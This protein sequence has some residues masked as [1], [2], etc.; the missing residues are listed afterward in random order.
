MSGDQLIADNP[1][2]EKPIW[3]SESGSLIYPSAYGGGQQQGYAAPST[4][5]EPA[6]GGGFQI[7]GL[8]G[9]R[10]TSTYRTPAHN[11][12][13]G[14]VRNSYHT[15]RDAQGNPL[16]RDSVP[17]AGMSMASYAARLRSENPDKDVINEGDHVHIEPRGRGPQA[18]APTQRV[19]VVN[20]RAPRERAG[21]PERAP[22]GYRFNGD[23]LEAIP[24][25]PADKRGGGGDAPTRREVVGLR[26]EFNALPEV[27]TFNVA[28]QQFNTLRDLSYKKN[29]TPQD[30]IAIVFAFMKTLDPSSVVKETEFA[31]AAN[32]ASVPESVRNMYN[33]ALQGTRL[34]A[35][36][37]KQMA[38]T[39]FVSYKAFREAH[40]QAAEQYR[41]YARGTGI[42]PDDVART[43]TPDKPARTTR[44]VQAMKR[45]QTQRIG[46]F[47]VTAE[48]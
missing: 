26:K 5:P 48:N 4:R 29:P 42:R 28:R 24:G 3:D 22:S 18:S 7:A 36:Q 6:T 46:R 34:N 8:P 10:V 25:G 35:E 40:N 13:V 16:A 37:R 14:G 2:V 27:K 12:E 17:P 23:S 20:V 9:E 45:G 41:G 32:A 30:D 44:T 15:R 31:T 1:V 39:A 43:Y 47:I 38:K 21:R 19:G 33:K 11:S